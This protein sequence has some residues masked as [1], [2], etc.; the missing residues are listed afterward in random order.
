MCH[1][2][3]KP[4]VT[5]VAVHSLS[6]QGEFLQDTGLTMSKVFISYLGESSAMIR[7]TEPVSHKKLGPITAK[8]D[9]TQ[10]S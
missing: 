9:Y 7:T 8:V 3:T 6:L 10:M 5:K 4:Y 2:S 1:L